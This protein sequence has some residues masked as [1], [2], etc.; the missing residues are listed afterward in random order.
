MNRRN[1][2][3]LLLGFP[4]ISLENTSEVI[5]NSSMAKRPF[6]VKVEN[7]IMTVTSGDYF[8][9]ASIGNFYQEGKIKD[10][11]RRE[12]FLNTNV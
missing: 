7:N 8:A 1:I 3:G 4:G 12:K 9:Q 5:V 2:F 10:S 6:D 11:K